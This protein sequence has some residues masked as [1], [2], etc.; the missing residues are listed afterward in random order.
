MVVKW[1][2]LPKH[3][4]SQVQSRQVEHPYA[5]CPSRPAFDDGQYPQQQIGLLD[6]KQ[7]LTCGA[8]FD[9]SELDPWMEKSSLSCPQSQYHVSV[10]QKNQELP[11]RD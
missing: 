6:R 1:I 11:W 7:Y 10:L 4:G 9:A 2:S 3:E 8:F 5:S